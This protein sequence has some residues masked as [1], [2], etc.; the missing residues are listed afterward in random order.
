MGFCFP[1]L[2]CRGN[3]GLGW[4]GLAVSTAYTLVLDREGVRVLEGV[5]C[6]RK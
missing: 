1:A 4:V 5:K 3:Q 6:V 2:A